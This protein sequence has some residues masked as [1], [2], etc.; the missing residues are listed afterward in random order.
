[1]VVIKRHEAGALSDLLREA[2][3][4]EVRSCRV[5]SIGPD[6][7]EE[8]QRSG[9][10]PLAGLGRISRRRKAS[11]EQKWPLQGVAGQLKP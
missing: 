10:G 8:L 4:A 1:M 2:W 3:K 9:R 11:S 7:L 5:L 6:A